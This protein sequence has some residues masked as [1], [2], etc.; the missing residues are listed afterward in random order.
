M[1]TQS[2]LACR[3]IHTSDVLCFCMI[4]LASCLNSSV[5]YWPIPVKS[6]VVFLTKSNPKY[7]YKIQDTILDLYKYSWTGI[8]KTADVF[9]FQCTFFMYM[10]I[11]TLYV[12]LRHTP[13][14]A[15]TFTFICDITID[16]FFD[17]NKVL[18]R[19]LNFVIKFF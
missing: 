8:Q 12:V 15:Y 16:C 13:N 17:F 11:A 5:E 6:T 9:F 1:Y 19:F 2:F 10:K 18:T 4:V 7:S 14:T 3:S